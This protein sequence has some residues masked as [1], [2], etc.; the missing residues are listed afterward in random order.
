MR[1]PIDDSPYSKRR[2]QLITKQTIDMYQICD[3][4]VK[5]ISAPFKSSWVEVLATTGPQFGI[6][7][8]SHAWANPFTET[9]EMLDYHAEVKGLTSATTYWFCVFANVSDCLRVLWL[10]V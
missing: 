3:H 5:P 2:G 9:I 4:L 7:F 1:S 10:R 8:L 6:Y